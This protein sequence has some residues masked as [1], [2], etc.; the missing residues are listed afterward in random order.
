MTQTK[1]PP[2]TPYQQNPRESLT[3]RLMYWGMHGDAVFTRHGGVEIGVEILLPSGIGVTDAERERLSTSLRE[4][5][6][7]YVP[8]GCRLRLMVGC[9]RLPSGD[10]LE[11]AY[12]E[13]YENGLLAELA[14]QQREQVTNDRLRGGLRQWRYSLLLRLPG[15]P[16]G[17]LSRS[18]V[19]YTPQTIRAVVERAQLAREQLMAGMQ[20]A[21]FQ[22]RAM[23]AQESFE[24]IWRYFNPGLASASPPSYS[25]EALPPNLMPSDLRRQPTLQT[26]SL[27][28]QVAHSEVDASRIDALVVGDRFVFTVNLI[29]A[30]TSTYAGM[31]EQTLIRLG[32]HTFWYV[33]DCVHEVQS[34][35]RTNINTNAAGAMVNATDPSAS[36]G[37]MPDVGNAAVLDQLQQTIYRLEANREHIYRFG[38]AFVV[39]TD[40]PQER[41]QAA[42]RAATELNGLGGGRALVGTVQNVR[43][44]FDHLAPFS[45]KDSIFLFDAF[46]ANVADLLPLTGP[47]RGSEQPVLVLRSR[48]GTQV[49][50]NPSDDTLNYGTLV[51]GG[52]GSGKTMLVQRFLLSLRML[53][54]GAIIVDQKEDYRTFVELM[55]GQFINF[56]PNETVTQLQPDGQV[57]D[58]PV[59]YNA[60]AWPDDPAELETQKSFALAFV[61]VLLGQS[62]IG[63]RQTVMVYAIE[64]LYRTAAQRRSEGTPVSPTLSDLISTLRT[65][66]SLGGS[67]TM[68]P[69]L[70]ELA[71]EMRTSLLTYSGDTVYGRFLDGQSTIDLEKAL[72]Y[73][74]ISSLRDNAT[75]KPIALMLI[76]RL[77]WRK[78]RQDTQVKVPVIEELGVL[79]QIPEARDFVNALFKLIR[80]YNG[81]P[82]AVSQEVADFEQAGGLINNMS[83]VLIGRVSPQEASRIVE[84]FHLDPAVEDLIN[85]LGGVKGMMREYLLLRF[86]QSGVS[87]DVVQYAPTRGEYW[88][89]TSNPEDKALRE[90][91]IRDHGGNVGAAIR[92]LSRNG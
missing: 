68:R 56:S 76:M 2:A 17:R 37:G 10:V 58:V 64:Q 48:Q 21:G 79:L 43:Q 5:L 72:V 22:A 51:I 7:G 54:A 65:M 73:F 16:R 8:E 67:E 88:T 74:N 50:L 19:P 46:S 6:T 66:S 49:G 11:P 39:V 53:G 60:F 87:G 42:E 61:A 3:Q 9:S 40:S 31:V 13:V 82:V 32:H 14:A 30:P 78:A 36:I 25:S 70:I 75:L 20:L 85:S 84:L 29:G 33:L 38:I 52:S 57:L 23:T 89:F 28:E 35:R 12:E 41:E 26:R 77:I 62:L 81:W 71:D 91:A 44:Y 86:T 80:A 83:Q 15:R 47:Y 1:P 34:R 63:E 18:P 92:T 24:L 59:R 4:V 90:R 27:R 69:H 55:D 45:G